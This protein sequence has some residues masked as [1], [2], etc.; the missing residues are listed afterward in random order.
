MICV[1]NIY[2]VGLTLEEIQ[3]KLMVAIVNPPVKIR[4]R[5]KTIMVKPVGK[6]PNLN[7]KINFLSF[8]GGGKYKVYENGKGPFQYDVIMVRSVGS[9]KMLNL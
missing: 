8:E 1:N 3:L 7:L 6:S 9:L 5:A 2:M 4:F